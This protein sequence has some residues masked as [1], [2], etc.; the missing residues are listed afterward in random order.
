MATG[1][2]IFIFDK[3]PSVSGHLDRTTNCEETCTEGL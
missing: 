2:Y 3:I 1:L